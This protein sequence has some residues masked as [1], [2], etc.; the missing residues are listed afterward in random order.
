MI[1]CLDNTVM[2]SCR[3]TGCLLGSLIGDCLGAPFEMS[4]FGDDGIKR[5]RIE[6]TLE[7][8]LKKDRKIFKYTGMISLMIV[9]FYNNCIV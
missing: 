5:K 4:Y 7:K 9:K 3:Y 2:K 6:E 1:D 8:T